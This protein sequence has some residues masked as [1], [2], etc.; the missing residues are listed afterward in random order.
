MHFHGIIKHDINN[1]T[2]HFHFYQPWY[3]GSKMQKLNFLGCVC[4]KVAKFTFWLLYTTSKKCEFTKSRLFWQNSWVSHDVTVL[5]RKSAK[6]SWRAGSVSA[7]WL[8]IYRLDKMLKFCIVYGCS[9]RS[10]RKKGKKLLLS[11]KDKIHHSKQWPDVC[12]H[13]HTYAHIWAHSHQRI[14]SMCCFTHLCLWHASWIDWTPLT[15]LN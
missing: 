3:I 8:R 9:N 15:A 7:D 14:E 5:L 2:Q 6:V 10:N 11:T 12:T 1:N 4:L 13:T